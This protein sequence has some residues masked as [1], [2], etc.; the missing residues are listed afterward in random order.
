MTERIV[1]LDAQTLNPG[2]LSWEAFQDLGDVSI[3]DRT[4]PSL[5]VSRS[6]EATAV[7]TNKVTLD[8]KTIGQLPR[9]Q[10]IG[11]TA[12]G[13]NIIDVDAAS[14]HDVTVANVPVYGTDSVAQHTIALMLDLARGIRA[15]DAA[16]KRGEWAEGDD[17]CLPCGP[18]IEL[19]GR[20]LGIVGFGRIGLAVARIGQAMGMRIIAARR[21]ADGHTTVGGVD[22][23]YVPVDRLFQQ[24][25]VV[26]LHCP[27]TNE[28]AEIVNAD[29][30]RLMKPTA[31]LINTSRGQLI[32]Q[33]ALAQA[34]RDE[35]IAAAAL[36][37][38]DVEPPASDN[39][40]L[41]APRCLI[42]PHVAWYAQEARARLLAM[43]AENLKAFINGNPQNV[44]NRE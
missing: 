4:P 18:I 35:Q 44:V 43:S 16:V 25:D 11:V 23:E 37:V 19:S 33:P 20:T 12:T 39:P 26:S 31:F 28:T 2:D 21:G 5:V 40:L 14:A 10:Y 3:H 24:S 9:L 41:S 7:I 27:L 29:R 42:T 32:D 34:L 8:A 15:H 13:H 17:F 1:I 6:M 22:V 36:D 38:L 30:L